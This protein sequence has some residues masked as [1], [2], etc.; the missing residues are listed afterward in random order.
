M[1]PSFCKPM[2]KNLGTMLFILVIRKIT[3]TGVICMLYGFITN[4]NSLGRGR[5]APTQSVEFEEKINLS[6]Q[7]ERTLG[8]FRVGKVNSGRISGSHDCLKHVSNAKFYRERLSNISSTGIAGK[9]NKKVFQ[10]Q[11]WSLCFF[12]LYQSV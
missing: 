7:R 3:H 1:F 10:A 4:T 11:V 8:R 6:D 9:Q 12:Q 2:F 5:N